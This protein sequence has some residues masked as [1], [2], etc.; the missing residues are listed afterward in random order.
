MKMKTFLLG[1]GAA[2][3]KAAIA[4]I[5]D[6]I[7]DS[8][9]VRLVN[10]TSKDIPDEYKINTDLVLPLPSA[11]GGCGKEPSKGR[12]AAIDA[13]RSKSINLGNIID[14]DTKQ[15]VL[16]TSTEGGTGCGATP[17]I[18]KY[19]E[20]MNMPVHIFAFIG[21]QDEARGINNT[22]KFFKE[23]SDS[24]ILHTI[25]NERFKDFS[26]NYTKA[27]EAANKE[28]TKQLEILLGGKLVCSDQN[29]DD[30]DLYKLVTTS[31][32]MDIKHVKLAGIKSVAHSNEI[33]KNAFDNALCLDYEPGCKRLGIIIDAPQRIIDAI[34]EKF[35]VVKRYTGE[36]Y[37]LF[38]HIQSTGQSTCTMDIIISGLSYPE[39]AIKS[40]AEKYSTIKNKVSTE[41]KSFD[42]IFEGIDIDEEDNEFDVD[43][44]EKEKTSNADE[45]F[46]KFITRINNVVI[47]KINPDEY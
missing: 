40:I 14:Q 27:E 13:I 47:K 44:E 43:I 34:D 25:C 42:A 31:G 20:A 36:P 21:F 30:T 33:I 5:E 46:D 12:K 6:K 38:R 9:Y 8:K 17:I 22:L 2:G 18:A 24:V 37:E 7:I 15:V 23:L 39:S 19:L 3:N 16:V 11:L 4:A 10:T 32:Y 41:T 35:E 28:F 45:A 1:I 26:G 29:I